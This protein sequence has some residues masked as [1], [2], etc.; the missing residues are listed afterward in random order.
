[1]K[2]TLRRLTGDR[3]IDEIMRAFIGAL[4]AALPNRILSVSLSGSMANG[5]AV[6]ASDI[7]GVVVLGGSIAD[8]DIARFAEIVQDCSL[9]A[10]VH[11]DF[12]LRS[13]DAL[14]SQG[15]LP[16]KRASRTLIYGDDSSTAV[17]AMS[18]GQYILLVMRGSFSCLRHFRGLTGQ[19]HYPLPYPDPEGEF[20][21]YERRGYRSL[22]G[23]DEPG[24]KALVNG[25]TLAS[26]T[27]VGIRTGHGVVSRHDSVTAY[28]ERIGDRWSRLIESAYARC[29][30]VWGYRVPRAPADR[31]ELRRLCAQVPAFENY[32]LRVC[33]E[34][35]RVELSSHDAG[36]RLQAQETLA[37]LD[38]GGGT[39]VE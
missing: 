28:R 23:W 2:P 12:A 6:A 26:T 24:T 13:Q 22:T 33:H 9:D 21:G 39:S 20:F 3:Q 31:A 37:L 1:M 10:G 18:I 11:L 8:N 38:F 27:I 15:E 14:L 25:L 16:A 17:P 34:H 32:Y 29:R 19:L 5:T 35:L 30:A 4:E 7:D 36:R